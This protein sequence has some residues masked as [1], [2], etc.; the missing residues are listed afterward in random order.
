MAD[1]IAG[2]PF[3]TADE[4][5]DFPHMV[6]DLVLS[7]AKALGETLEFEDV[8]IVWFAF[9]LGN[10]KAICST[11]IPD[12]RIYEVTFNRD[13]GEAY[14]DTYKKTHNIAITINKEN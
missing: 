7:Q 9:V 11:S 12:G 3:S 4:G 1:D 2:I 10:L 14:V 13:K 8:Y 6:K 5:I